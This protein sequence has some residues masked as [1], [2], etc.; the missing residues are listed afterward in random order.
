MAITENEALS[1]LSVAD[2]KLELR[3]QAT[4][5]EHDVLLSGQ[6]TAAAGFVMESTGVGVADLGPLRA[7]IIL[8]VRQ[9]YDGYRDIRPTEAFYAL[10]Q[11][12]R[13]YKKAE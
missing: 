13:S 9:L 6:I 3:I 8:T 10:M 12:F 1:I 2:M 4:E 11:P 5:S 7:A